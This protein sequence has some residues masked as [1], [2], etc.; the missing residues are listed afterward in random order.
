MFK[1][2][3]N[4]NLFQFRLSRQLTHVIVCPYQ[5]IAIYVRTDACKLW[6]KRAHSQVAC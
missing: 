2:N 1:Q 6:V 3:R 5:A 4:S